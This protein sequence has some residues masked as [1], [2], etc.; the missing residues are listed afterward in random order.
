[1]A[2]ML[3]L[4]KVFSTFQG[5]MSTNIQFLLNLTSSERMI[6]RSEIHFINSKMILAIIYSCMSGTTNDS[7]YVEKTSC[8]SGKVHLELKYS[9]KLTT[10]LGSVQDSAF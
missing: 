6:M 7:L 8:N 3:F 9:T 10:V 2:V 1:M 4:I 5:Y